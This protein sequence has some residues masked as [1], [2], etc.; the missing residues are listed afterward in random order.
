MVKK[1]LLGLLVLLALGAGALWLTVGRGLSEANEA[2]GRETAPGDYALQD[3][4]KL[5]PP[6]FEP[7]VAQPPNPLKNVYWGDTHIHTRESFDATLFGTTAH[8]RGRLP[9]RTGR[10]SCAPTAARRCSSRVPSTSSRSPTTPRA[11][12]CGRAVEIRTSLVR[13]GSTAR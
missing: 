6:P 4:S 11:S 2:Y 3:D 9:L 7:A 10:G 1:V 13:V 12:A 8:D 5:G